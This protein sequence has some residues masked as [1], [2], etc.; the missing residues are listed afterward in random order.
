MLLPDLPFNK[1]GS[2]DRGKAPVFV[3]SIINKCGK[4]RR[5]G[6]WEELRILE[7]QQDRFQT[8]R[9]RNDAWFR[10]FFSRCCWQQPGGTRTPKERATILLERHHHPSFLS[11][12][13]CGLYKSCIWGRGSTK[14]RGVKT[15]MFL[16]FLFAFHLP[17]SLRLPMLEN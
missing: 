6:L 5:G 7:R 14:Y 9:S 2:E 17:Y 13:R 11:L 16:Y 1:A 10:L 3:A 4:K 15:I 8:G 12:F